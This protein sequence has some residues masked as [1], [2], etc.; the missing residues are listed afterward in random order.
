VKH[1]Q[2]SW[3][4]YTRLGIPNNV[5]GNPWTKYEAFESMARLAAHRMWELARD[6]LMVQVHLLGYTDVARLREAMGQ[7]VNGGAWA[8]AIF[9]RM[10]GNRLL[11]RLLGEVVEIQLAWLLAN[12]DRYPNNPAARYSQLEM[13]DWEICLRV[14]RALVYAIFDAIAAEEREWRL[15]PDKPGVSATM[16]AVLK[17]LGPPPATPMT[18]PERPQP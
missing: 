10:A 7:K 11:H 14:T 2:D 16:A 15:H 17:S 8:T 3:A 5:P 6:S 1:L 12:R 9:E 4:E 13:Q 18:R